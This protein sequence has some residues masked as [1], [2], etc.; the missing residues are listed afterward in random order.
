MGTAVPMYEGGVVIIGGTAGCCQ[1]LPPASAGRGREGAAV[2]W[3]SK[4]VGWP[5]LRVPT[6]AGGGGQ[7][8][9][10]RLLGV[11]G[12]MDLPMVSNSDA[13]G[14]GKN[15][16]ASAGGRMQWDE[17]EEGAKA[18]NSVG[19]EAA[20]KAEVSG[21]WGLAGTGV[22]AV[23]RE[24]ATE[25]KASNSVGPSD[26]KKALASTAAPGGDGGARG[27]GDAPRSPGAAAEGVAGSVGLASGTSAAAVAEGVLAVP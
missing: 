27:G 16:L 8:W 5:G 22:N 3:K 4:E 13:P 7:S 17:G 9:A 15:A 10:S 20:K 18:S 14:E 26:W 24:G 6:A 19:L 1:R 2:G 23:G 21:V 25:H 12:A 11:G